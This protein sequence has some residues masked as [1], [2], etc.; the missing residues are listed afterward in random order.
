MKITQRPPI[1]CFKFKVKQKDIANFTTKQLLKLDF[2]LS[3]K[4]KPHHIVCEN[5]GYTPFCL[6]VN[7]LQYR[8]WAIMNLKNRGYKVFTP[9]S[10]NP[11]EM[12]NIFLIKSPK[13][14][15]AF[16]KKF[17]GFRG[18]FNAIKNIVKGEKAAH[19]MAEPIMKTR[20]LDCFDKTAI[21]YLAAS[22]SNKHSNQMF[23][24]ILSNLNVREIEIKSPKK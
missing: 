18:L 10:N 7:K 23:Q 8:D 5:P 6:S 3:I 20:E 2:V 9:P 15:K 22:E 17:A 19:T 1:D 12:V 13:A 11:E 4:D 24:D 16:E 14:N 21:K